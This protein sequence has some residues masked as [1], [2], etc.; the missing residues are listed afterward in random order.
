MVQKIE[1]LVM[2][3]IKDFVHVFWIDFHQV[4]H[5][6][7]VAAT[8]GVAEWIYWLASIN[9][10]C[11]IGHICRG[12]QTKSCVNG[13]VDDVLEVALDVGGDVVDDEGESGKPQS[14]LKVKLSKIG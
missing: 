6:D 1:S 11:W 5:S 13:V 2:D 7:H 8:S 12:H 14:T 3:C 4:V 9:D 10:H